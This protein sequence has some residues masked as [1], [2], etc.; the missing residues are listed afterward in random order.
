M[1]QFT[2][3]QLH[4]KAKERPEGY[5]ADVLSCATVNGEMVEMHG[6]DYARL[7][8]KY[9]T[10]EE[11]TVNLTITRTPLPPHPDGMVGTELKKLLSM[12][13]ITEK[14]NCSCNKRARAMDVAG[15]DW[16][17]QNLATIVA[18]L[19]EEATRRKLPF[20][21]T[22]GKALVRMAISRARHTAKHS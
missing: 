1:M 18:W 7:L 22:A 17:E 16:C 13:G 4:E 15:P 3:A 2:L 10:K 21:D 14:P 11:R 6:R 8:A 9:R 19:R 20:I 5:V 12:I